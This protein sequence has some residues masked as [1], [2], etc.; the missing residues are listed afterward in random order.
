M[1]YCQQITMSFDFHISN[2]H[3]SFFS[4]FVSFLIHK[5]LSVEFISVYYTWMVTILQV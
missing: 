4:P 1:F 3:L 5:Y 2:L